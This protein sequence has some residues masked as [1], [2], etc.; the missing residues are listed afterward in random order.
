[1]FLLLVWVWWFFLNEFLF[2]F[3]KLDVEM[4]FI[5][6]FLLELLFL[7]FF[8]ILFCVWR[9]LFICCVWLWSEVFVFCLFCF[10]FLEFL[11]KLFGNVFWEDKLEGCV[12]D[13]EGGVRSKILFVGFLLFIFW[14][15]IFW[16]F[17]IFGFFVGEII[18]NGVMCVFGENKNMFWLIGLIVFKCLFLFFDCCCLF[19]FNCF[20]MLL[21]INLVCIFLMV[22]SFMNIFFVFVFEILYG[23]LL[24]WVFLI[25][26]C[27]VMFFGIF[28]E[29]F[30]LIVWLNSDCF[31]VLGV[32]FFKFGKKLFLV[33]SGFFFILWK[34][35][36]LGL[37]KDVFWLKWWIIFGEGF[38][39]CIKI[40]L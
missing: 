13:L 29:L 40:G 23:F 16:V 25:D 3:C 31:L 39:F 18:V 14:G 20:V 17:I 36:L 4:V 27:F 37:F 35:L 5:F 9:R 22:W 19:I 10:L 21:L 33:L 6:K 7:L 34:F 32:I 24:F 26:C 1:M 2:W 30:L 11:F 8:S 12:W 28:G 38:I 15:C